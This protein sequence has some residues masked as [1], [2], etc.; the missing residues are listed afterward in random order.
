MVTYMSKHE[1]T[2]RQIVKILK[3]QG[4]LSMQGITTAL[5]ERK[6]YNIPSPH[7]LGNLMRDA[8][9]KVVGKVRTSFNC[10]SNVGDCNV[11]D[12]PK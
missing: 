12:L 6:W 1:R 3:K 10:N 5:V 7:Q 8:R 9:F 11:Y 2:K 4:P